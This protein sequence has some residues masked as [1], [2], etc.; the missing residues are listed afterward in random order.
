M[1]VDLDF[2]L[3]RFANEQLDDN[4]KEVAQLQRK[5]KTMRT[6]LTEI[7]QEDD[8]AICQQENILADNFSNDLNKNNIAIS[9]TRQMIENEFRKALDDIKIDI[10]II[11]QIPIMRNNNRE[12]NEEIRMASNKIRQQIINIDSELT[13]LFNMIDSN[14]SIH[15]CSRVLIWFRQ[16][17]G[18]INELNRIIGK[19]T[20]SGDLFAF[21]EKSPLMHWVMER[22]PLWIR[23][24]KL[25]VKFIHEM[26]EDSITSKHLID[27]LNRTTDTSNATKFIQH[28]IQDRQE[29]RRHRRE[30]LLHKLEIKLEEQLVEQQTRAT[31]LVS[32][33]CQLSARLLS[34]FQLNMKLKKVL[35]QVETSKQIVPILIDHNEE[36]KVDFLLIIRLEGNYNIWTS[37]KNSIQERFCSAFCRIMQVSTDSLRIDHIEESGV[38]LHLMVHAPYGPFVIKQISGRGKDNEFST[39]NI[40]TIQ[41][42]CAKFGSQIHSIVLGEC[43]LPIEK[44][45]MDF[46]WNKMRINDN[47]L[48]DNTYGFD[49]FDQENKESICP[50]GWKR[51]GI[52]VADNDADFDVQWGSWHI[53]YHGT[54]GSYAP[55]IL[56]SGL[57]V[58]TE[59]Y[60][61][62]RN[63]QT[64]C[65]SPS[66]EY[67]AHPRHTRLWRNIPNDGEKYR[68]YQLVFQCRVN[69]AVI[70]DPKPETL[71]QDI[72]KTTRIDNDIPNEELEW[73]IQATQERIRNYIVCYGLMIR[74]IDCEPSDLPILNWW[75][76]THYNEY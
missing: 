11:A 27:S 63:H 65:L 67:A 48:T 25:I 18:Y 42:C 43:T 68:Y 76:N 5:I 17:Y 73:I 41:K 4:I 69:P 22:A 12:N 28:Y 44:C 52:K 16:H 39:L 57:R 14:N 62:S 24:Q 6:K 38:I 61:I 23:R 31:E 47:R 55:F 71:L 45:L 30:Q 7:S 40:Q 72:H 51:I 58:S 36:K 1:D 59:Q 33:L 74:V 2:C 37:N 13:H 3:K 10:D 19:N 50:Q 64:I 53:A 70:D 49:S 34:E 15:S 9:T 32:A 75:K 66:I 20:N 8:K 29:A 46:K 56:S 21:S 35:H 54:Q 60:F 26:D